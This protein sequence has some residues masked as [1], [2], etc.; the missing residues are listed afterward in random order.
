MTHAAAL[1][2]IATLPPDAR[3]AA[4]ERIAIRVEGGMSEQKAVTLTADECVRNYGRPTTH[5]VP[6]CDD[7]PEAY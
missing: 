4:E 7:Q 1:S 5:P 2:C 3:E 6:D